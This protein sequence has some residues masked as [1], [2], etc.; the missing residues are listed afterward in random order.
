MPD[1]TA[2][3]QEFGTIDL[4]VTPGELSVSTSFTVPTSGL[5]W[6][7]V[8]VDS[9]TSAPSA[10]GWQGQY[11]VPPVP[12]M[13][14]TVHQIALGRSLW[15]RMAYSVPTG[16]VPATCPTTAWSDLGPQVRLRVA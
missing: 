13:P 7:A 6:M 11:T 14:V 1:G 15:L 9:Y 16:A 12:W 4:S 10:V 5:Y 3:I 2:L 8:L